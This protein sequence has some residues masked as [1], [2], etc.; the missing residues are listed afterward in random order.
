M[1]RIVGVLVASAA[2]VIPGTA[3]FAGTDSPQPAEYRAECESFY[4]GGKALF[5]PLL[6]SPLKPVFT[7]IEAGACG[8][9]KHA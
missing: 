4:Q 6:A 3:A 8:E 5:D 1:K 2:I 9:N 7:A